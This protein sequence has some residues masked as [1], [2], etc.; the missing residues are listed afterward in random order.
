MKSNGVKQVLKR[1]HFIASASPVVRGII[2]DM[3]VVFWL[4]ERRKKIRSYLKSHQIAKLQI[5]ASNNILDGWLNTDVFPAR[6]GVV[7]LDAT[8]RFPFDDET[9]DYVMAEHV[10]EHIDYS[11]GQAMLKECFRILRPGGRVRF[12]T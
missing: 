12:A 2:R 6:S 10:I 1:S 3:R 11:A 9:F 4:V 7:Y 5:G 8:R